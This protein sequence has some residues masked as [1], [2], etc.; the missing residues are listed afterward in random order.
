MNDFKFDREAYLKRINYK[1]DLTVSIDC[2]RQ[3]HCAQLFTIPFENFDIVLGKGIDLE[4][5]KLFDKL[6]HHRRGG[7]CFE[8]NGLFLMALQSFG[9]DARALLG[10]VHSSDPPSGKGH[11]FTLINID[12]KQWI[13]D[14][15]FG[16]GTMQGPLPLVLDQ[17]TSIFQ[18][19]FRLVEA[20]PYGTML[21]MLIDGEWKNQYSFTLNHVFPNDIAYGNHYTS[22]APDSF[23][24][25]SRVAALPTPDG[26]H[27]LYN[28]SLKRYDGEQLYLEELEENSAYIIALE[29]VFGIK[30][31]ASISDLKPLERRE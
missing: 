7:Y 17:E 23:F 10:R 5:A 27:T 6:V 2:L 14:V 25:R 16:N 21:Q 15:G 9:F 8:L 26:T 29:E 19:T 20:Y 11:Q 28:Y 3:L 13:A 18:Q 12:G 24:V 30:L 22:T 1:N 31:D 4:P